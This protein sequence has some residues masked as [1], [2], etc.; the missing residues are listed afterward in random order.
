MKTGFIYGYDYHA[1]N[2]LADVLSA[3]PRD[4]DYGQEV[5]QIGG[6]VSQDE[7]VEIVLSMMDAPANPWIGENGRIDPEHLSS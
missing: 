5:G 4:W 6:E 2:I 7:A 1:H 3:P